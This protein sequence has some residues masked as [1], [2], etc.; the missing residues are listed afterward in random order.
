[1]DYEKPVLAIIIVDDTTNVLVYIVNG[2]QSDC[3]QK[4]ATPCSSIVLAVLNIWTEFRVCS[5]WNKFHQ[6][7]YIS[8]I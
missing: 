8:L 4:S 1:M 6:K 3:W 5:K 2:I 7:V